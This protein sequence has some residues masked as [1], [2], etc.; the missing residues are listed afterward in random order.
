M[1]DK[2][3]KAIVASKGGVPTTVAT[4]RKAAYIAPI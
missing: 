4:E 2:A 3:A 1:L